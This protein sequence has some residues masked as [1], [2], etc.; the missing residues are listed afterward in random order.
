MVGSVGEVGDE[1][2]LGKGNRY[3]VESKWR[4]GKKYIT[5]RKR[6]KGRGIGSLVFMEKVMEVL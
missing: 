4:F 2:L 5:S 1:V 3:L 6:R